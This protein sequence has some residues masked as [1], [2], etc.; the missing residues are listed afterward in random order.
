[1]QINDQMI[2]KYKWFQISVEEKLTYCTISGTNFFCI[3]FVSYKVEA[4]N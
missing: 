3:V 2:T 4:Y 1:M